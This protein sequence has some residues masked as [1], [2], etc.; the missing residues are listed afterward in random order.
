M[1][2]KDYLMLFVGLG[3]VAVTGVVI[4]KTLKKASS[5]ITKEQKEELDIKVVRTDNK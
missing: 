2:K 3:L 5:N 1:G 4:Y